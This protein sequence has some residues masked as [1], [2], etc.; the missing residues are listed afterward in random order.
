[1]F[2]C[3]IDEFQQ[4]LISLFKLQ[5]DPVS[6]WPSYAPLELRRVKH[7]AVLVGLIF[8]NSGFI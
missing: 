1:M 2:V 7:L 5:W 8:V 6:G 4:T 3:V